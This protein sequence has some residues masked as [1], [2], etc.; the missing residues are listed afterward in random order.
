LQTPTRS[1]YALLALG[2]LLF[3]TIGCSAPEASNEP[4][5][6]QLLV[7]LD[8]LRPDYV[9]AELMPN[10]HRLAEKGVRFERHHSVFPTVTRVNAAS[11][12]TGAYPESH[13]LLGNTVYSPE[14]DAGAGL[15]TSSRENLVRM[16]AA[17]GRLLDAPDLG[18]LFADAG[19]RVLAVSSGSPGSA[20]LLNHHVQGGLLHTDFS[21]PPEL[22]P[23]VAQRLGEVPPDATPNTAR[24]R[25]A[26]DLLLDV[27]LPEIAPQLAI[28]WL[29]DPDHTAHG[30]GIGSSEAQESLRLVDAELGRLLDELARR[31]YELNVFVTSDHGFSTHTA[32]FEVVD[33]IVARFAASDAG[34]TP[35]LLRVGHAIYDL[36]HDDDRLA[37]LVSALQLSPGIG[38]IFTAGDGDEPAGSYP[39]TL[40]FG[41]A[42]WQHA[43]SG[44][45]LL[46]A[47]WSDEANELGW[48]GSS[49]AGGTAGHGSSGRWDIHNTLVAA[50]PDLCTAT[51]S[52]VP[53]ANVDLAPTLLWL[54][55]I[56]VP[57]SVSGRVLAEAM[58]CDSPPP[59]VTRSEVVVETLNEGLLY[60]LTAHLSHVGDARY[61]D[62][63]VVER[64]P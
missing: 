3:A 6:L 30:S 41:A 9:T 21:L 22:E 38:A 11:L 10:L 1:L 12:V 64:G 46:S 33:E 42:R 45:I 35:D 16:Q 54:A 17:E 31:G 49:T 44:A 60:R 62:Y 13:G 26:V 4:G 15:S 57:A 25:R 19:K 40:S 48:A 23:I 29:S 34:G 53:T 51:V 58:S 37:E 43:R 63:T 28:L 24:N 50:G 14:V 36:A 7:V 59:P 55:G 47:D 2:A 32:G 61:L 27:G 56:D 39:G 5:R 20:W 18:S 52:E 8:G